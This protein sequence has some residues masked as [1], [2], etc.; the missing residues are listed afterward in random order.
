MYHVAYVIGSAGFSS[1]LPPHTQELVRF[2][3][4]TGLGQQ[5]VQYQGESAAESSRTLPRLSNH[6]LKKNL[7][8]SRPSVDR[9]QM[10]LVEIFGPNCAVCSALK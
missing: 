6:C 7:N 9:H 4:C 8:A 10:E 2:P 5:T 1:E 3:N